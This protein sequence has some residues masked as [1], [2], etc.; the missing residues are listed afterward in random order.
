MSLT[1][2]VTQIYIFVFYFFS[3]LYTVIDTVELSAATVW[4]WMTDATLDVLYV[5]SAG[6]SIF[7]HA[8]IKFDILYEAPLR[9]PVVCVYEYVFLFTVSI[10]HWINV[11]DML[12]M[13]LSAVKLILISWF[14]WERLRLSVKS[15]ASPFGHEAP[16]P[17][18]R[19]CAFCRNNKSSHTL[20]TSESFSLVAQ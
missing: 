19:P 20:Y 15:C 16:S 14:I 18:V 2:R 1:S 6:T 17:Y 11:H 13:S 4:I 3:Q 10:R 5:K 12:F 8:P 7:Q 9:K